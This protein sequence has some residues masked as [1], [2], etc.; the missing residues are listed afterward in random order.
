[1]ALEQRFNG[2]LRSGKRSK[3]SIRMLGIRGRQLPAPGVTSVR[4]DIKTGRCRLR[5]K[6]RL[7]FA[8]ANLRGKVLRS[9]RSPG[10]SRGG[11][12][13]QKR[14][15]AASK[16]QTRCSRDTW[17]RHHGGHGTLAKANLQKYSSNLAKNHTCRSFRFTALG[18]TCCYSD[19]FLS[20][21]GNQTIPTLP[22]GLAFLHRQYVQIYREELAPAS[23]PLLQALT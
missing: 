1:M 16:G 10:N 8:G 4:S 17:G 14:K 21:T 3:R 15:Y 20:Q 6:R 9:I 5:G 12:H 13:H 22:T 23:R 19:R 7:Q 2:H 11:N 18:S